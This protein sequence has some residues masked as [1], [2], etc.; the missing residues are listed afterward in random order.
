[1]EERKLLEHCVIEEVVCGAAPPPKVY[2]HSNIDYILDSDNNCRSETSLPNGLLLK[3]LKN[4]VRALKHT[5]EF[6]GQI[7]LSKPISPTAGE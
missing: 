7:Q 6:L 3:I 5:A 2:A 4:S 1:M